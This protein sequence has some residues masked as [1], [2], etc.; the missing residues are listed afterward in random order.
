MSFKHARLK[1]WLLQQRFHFE[2]IEPLFFPFFL[3]LLVRP[4][5]TDAKTKSFMVVQAGNAARFNINFEVNSSDLKGSI[6]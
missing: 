4:R 5:F 2:S 1:Y 3:P 6:V